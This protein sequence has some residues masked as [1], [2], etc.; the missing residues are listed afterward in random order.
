MP[1]GIAAR[2]NKRPLTAER[3]SFGHELLGRVQTMCWVCEDVARQLAEGD[4]AAIL[5][6][7]QLEELTGRGVV[8]VVVVAD[9]DLARSLLNSL[10]LLCLLLC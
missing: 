9:H 2:S 8:G 1:L 4:G 3:A 6:S 10:D 5:Q 7:L